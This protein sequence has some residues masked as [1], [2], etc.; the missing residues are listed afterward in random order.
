MPGYDAVFL[1][2]DG[3]LAESADIKTRAFAEMY[4]PYGPDVVD[5][6]IAHHKAHAG[7]SRR[8]KIR[9]CHKIIL[10]MRLSEDELEA[11]AQRFSLL[12]E[13]AV[14]AAD[15]VPGA[16]TFLEAHHGLVPLFVVSGTPEP[17]LRRIVGRRAMGAYFVAVRGSPP[18]KVPI[19]RALLEDHR[20][21]PEEVLFVGDSMTDYRAAAATGLPF[22]GRVAAGDEN[23]FPADTKIVSDLSGLLV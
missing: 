10:G 7:V 5:A 14:V 11:L 23:P 13:D 9:Y 4:R 8:K 19:I 2:F 6:V 17:E 21:K 22:V 12:V 20:L 15:W 1:D 16:R 18:S 3:V